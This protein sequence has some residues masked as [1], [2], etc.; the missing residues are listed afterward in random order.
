MDGSRPSDQVNRITEHNN[1]NTKTLAIACNLHTWYD[2]NWGRSRL[3]HIHIHTHV[4]ISACLIIWSCRTYFQPVA[5]VV[6][7]F[8]EFCRVPR[9]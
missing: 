4:F 8:N 5:A 2:V 1:K 3:V 6:N 7:V 9:E